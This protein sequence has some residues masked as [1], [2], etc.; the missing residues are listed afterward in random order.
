MTEISELDMLLNRLSKEELVRIV[1]E[2]C[3][4]DPMLK[5]SLLLKYGEEKSDKRQVQTFK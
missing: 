3:E 4:Q 1:A 2:V 5:N